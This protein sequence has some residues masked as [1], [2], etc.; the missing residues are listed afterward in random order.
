MN[1][2]SWQWQPKIL[3]FSTIGQLTPTPYYITP[4]TISAPFTCICSATFSIESFIDTVNCDVTPL[5]CYHML[6][7]NLPATCNNT[8]SVPYV[9]IAAISLLLACLNLLGFLFLYVSFCIVVLCPYQ[10]RYQL[11]TYCR[12]IS[13]HLT[14]PNFWICSNKWV[15][16]SWEQHPSWTDRLGWIS[17]RRLL[18]CKSI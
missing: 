3:N 2:S 16:G 11:I 17:D 15:Q 13:E 8:I 4:T 7:G 14:K 10:H 5:D 6:L 9:F 18:H 1:N 12:K